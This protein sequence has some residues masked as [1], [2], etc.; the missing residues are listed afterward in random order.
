MS[1]FREVRLSWKDQEF[2]IKPNE[3]MGAIAK[4]EEIITL[5]ELFDFYQK[6]NAPLAKLAIAFTA[7]LT[8]AGAKVSE[9][10]VYE[11][12]FNRDG[13]N[14]MVASINTLLSMMIPPSSLVKAGK[15]DADPTV[16]ESL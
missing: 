5:Q 1:V 6:G 2:V 3:V 11:A 13:Q 9:D 10:Q 16:G 4:V 12:M 14:S 8:Y 15:E 7:V